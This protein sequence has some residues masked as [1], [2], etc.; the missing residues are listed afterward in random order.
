MP[1]ITT[2]IS[3]LF[4]C[5]KT[6]ASRFKALRCGLTLCIQIRAGKVS[7]PIPTPPLDHPILKT[8]IGRYTV[9][10]LMRNFLDTKKPFHEPMH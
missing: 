5:R 3:I 10:T 2:G 9:Y 7:S 1:K 6:I 4:Y 8:A